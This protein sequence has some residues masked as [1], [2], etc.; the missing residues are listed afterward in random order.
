MDKFDGIPENI[1]D[2]ENNQSDIVSY[3]TSAQLCVHPKVS[4]VF[5]L[6][7]H[8]FVMDKFDAPLVPL[9]SPD[10]FEKKL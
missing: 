9:L 7:Y 5:P 6:F 4:T 2:W 10:V 8:Y 3:L 1:K